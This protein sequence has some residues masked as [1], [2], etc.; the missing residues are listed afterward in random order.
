MLLPSIVAELE[1]RLGQLENV[2]QTLDRSSPQTIESLQRRTT[3]LEHEVM[4]L[5]AQASRRIDHLSREFSQ[6]RRE[7]DDARLEA[8]NLRFD[9]AQL[10]S[11]GN[12]GGQA[13]PSTG[14]AKTNFA[15]NEGT[16]GLNS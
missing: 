15:G 8:A 5:R 1:V 16:Y 3:S 11:H 14:Q 10:I 2:A 7:L 9:I 6:N 13:E 4:T 12:Q